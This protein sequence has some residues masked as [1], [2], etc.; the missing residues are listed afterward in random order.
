MTTLAICENGH[1]VS[2]S[3]VTASVRTHLFEDGRV[4]IMDDMNRH[5]SERLRQL[6]VNHARYTGST[7]AR[8]VP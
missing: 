6:I 2:F 5:D 3:V 4:D 7:R 1:L 8:S